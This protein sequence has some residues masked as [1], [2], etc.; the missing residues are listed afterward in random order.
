MSLKSKLA[1]AYALLNK[2]DLPGARIV[3]DSV[4]DDEIPTPEQEMEY[5]TAWGKLIMAESIRDD[6]DNITITQKI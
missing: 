5:S 6:D 3:L 4:E 2:G 1:A